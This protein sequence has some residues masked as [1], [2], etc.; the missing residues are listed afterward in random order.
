MTLQGTMLKTLLL[1]VLLLLPAGFVWNM[2]F[3]GE[4]LDMVM[5]VLIGSSI[6]AAILGVVII[7]AKKAAPY[8]S[9]IYAVAE[10]VVLGTLSAFVEMQFKGIVIQAVMITLCIFA[11]MLFIYATGIIKVTNGLRTGIFAA[12]AGVALMYGVNMIM[13][14]FGGGMPFLH[15]SSPLGIGISAVVC[16]IAALNLLLDFEF[17]KQGSQGSLPKYYEWYGA[18]GLMMTL[19][20][21]YLEILRLLTKLRNR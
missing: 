10:G 12:T 18:F 2:F 21:L 1:F 6:L 11:A 7:F 17:I 20:W 8:L 14:L 9:P 5:P 15:E 3:K 16:I 19:I 4:Y 13:R